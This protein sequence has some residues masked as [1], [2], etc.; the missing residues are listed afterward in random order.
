MSSVIT[1]SIRHTHCTNLI[2]QTCLYCKTLQIRRTSPVKCFRYLSIIH[3]IYIRLFSSTGY[4]RIYSSLYCP[5]WSCYIPGWSTI[6][7][8]ISNTTVR[9]I[10]NTAICLS[11]N[12]ISRIYIIHRYSHRNF[13]CST[14]CLSRCQIKICGEGSR[15]VKSLNQ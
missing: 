15:G 6:L 10:I 14:L 4:Y 1:R 11:F 13:K 3:N 8:N 5:I 7:I 12:A 9:L 2:I